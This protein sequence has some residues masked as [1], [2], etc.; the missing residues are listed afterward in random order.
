MRYSF[1][2]YQHSGGYGYRILDNGVV[3]IT[4]EYSPPDPGETPMDEA[5]ATAWATTVTNNLNAE[6]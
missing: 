3:I 1:E 6:V 2:V 4:Q 5:T